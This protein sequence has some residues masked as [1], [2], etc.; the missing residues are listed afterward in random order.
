MFC[1]LYCFLQ[2]GIDCSGWPSY[3]SEQWVV[4][5]HYDLIYELFKI[6]YYLVNL[7]VYD[8]KKNIAVIILYSLRNIFHQFLS[9]I[10]P[11]TLAREQWSRGAIKHI[12]NYTIYIDFFH[13]FFFYKRHYNFD[14]FVVEMPVTL[15]TNVLKPNNLLHQLCHFD[16]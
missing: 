8:L 5:W 1:K 7:W 16:E 6:S 2:S 10:P 15:K 3:P 14:R 11:E 9:P 4:I 13:V 12:L